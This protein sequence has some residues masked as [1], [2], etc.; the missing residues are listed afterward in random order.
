MRK[1]VNF[2][3][4]TVFTCMTLLLFA[5]EVSANTP[6]KI[7]TIRTTLQVRRPALEPVRSLDVSPTGPIDTLDT[8]NEHVKV[9]LYSDNTW[10]YYKTP[11]FEAQKDVFDKCW[12]ESVS[13]PYKMSLGSLP[14][15]WSIW[16]VDSLGQ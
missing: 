15:S 2:K 3:Y 8:V 14:Y 12:D 16:L 5:G 6:Y 11:D 4:L 1:K 9:I 10:Q 7:D 13:N